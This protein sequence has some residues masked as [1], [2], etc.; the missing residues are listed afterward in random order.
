MYIISLIKCVQHN[1]LHISIIWCW[2][3][4]VREKGLKKY[5]DHPVILLYKTLNKVDKMQI[6]RFYVLLS[7]LDQFFSNFNHI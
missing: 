2:H 3:K 5:P 1:R 6:L 7:I 4:L